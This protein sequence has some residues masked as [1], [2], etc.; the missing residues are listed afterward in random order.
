MPLRTSRRA[1]ARFSFCGLPGYPP[2][3]SNRRCSQK[4]Q[5]A[6][7]GHV[8]G[9]RIAVPVAEV[10]V[11]RQV[12][13][14]CIAGLAPEDHVHLV[15]VGRL[16]AAV[17]AEA[18]FVLVGEEVIAKVVRASRLEEQFPVDS[19]QSSVRQSEL[20]PAV[21]RLPSSVLR[22]PFPPDSTG[23][24]TRISAGFRDF[25]STDGRRE[26]SYYGRMIESGCRL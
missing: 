7:F 17:L 15:A 3:Q 20:R 6:R 18:N 14:Q 1:F 9:V 21:L 2:E 12:G 11:E 16:R 4:R 26:A 19:S 10:L 13:R 25:A 24:A 23:S 8:E 22:L 5:R